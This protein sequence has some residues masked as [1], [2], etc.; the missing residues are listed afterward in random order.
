MYKVFVVLRKP[1]VY[2]ERQVI[3]WC[4]P[5]VLSMALTA[6]GFEVT[7]EKMAKQ[8]PYDPSWGTDH[9]SM[10]RAAES[11][12]RGVREVLVSKIDELGKRCRKECVI[13][14]FMD[15]EPSREPSFGAGNG[16]DGHYVLLDKLT[17]DYVY[18][19][20]PNPISAG[21]G[22]RKIKRDWFER[23]FWDIDR[24]NKVVEKWAL[25]IP[26]N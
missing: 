4:G 2:Q 17:R 22:F 18:V 23:H 25:V 8:A 7:Q 14:N 5:A 16:E 21:G 20:D 3:G 9:I 10:V 11:V 19:V 12:V 1:Y 13:V 24:G 6:L 15:T 26:A